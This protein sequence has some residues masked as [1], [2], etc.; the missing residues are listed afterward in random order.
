METPYISRHGS[1]QELQDRRGTQP[2]ENYASIDLVRILIET[3]TAGGCTRHQAHVKSEFLY[4]ELLTS[5][6][7]WMQ[8][9]ISAYKFAVTKF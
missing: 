1:L 6:T 4:T 7:I 8:F 3:S 2:T 9:G 5:T